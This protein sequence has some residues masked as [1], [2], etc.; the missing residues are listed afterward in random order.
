MKLN[1]YLIAAWHYRTLMAPTLYGRMTTNVGSRSS[2]LSKLLVTPPL[3]ANIEKLFLFTKL[4]QVPGTIESDSTKGIIA[5][6]NIICCFCASQMVKLIRFINENIMK[7]S[8][9]KNFLRVSFCSTIVYV[10]LLFAFG[11]NRSHPLCT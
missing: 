7:L 10:Y 11:S 1:G 9:E 8:L 6:D 5:V 2:F 3:V 4:Y